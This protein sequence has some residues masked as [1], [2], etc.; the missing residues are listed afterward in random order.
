M[1]FD[2]S[3]AKSEYLEPL[4]A[5]YNRSIS[6]T[7]D[8]MIENDNHKLKYLIDKFDF[9]ICEFDSKEFINLNHIE[10]YNRYYSSEKS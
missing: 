5:I 9:K 6:Q 7:L 10:E 2:L 1:C 4:C 8:N 3:I